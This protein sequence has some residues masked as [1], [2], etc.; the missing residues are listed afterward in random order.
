MKVLFFTIICI[1]F[2]TV[3]CFAH[4]PQLIDLKV[5]GLNIDIT[6]FHSVSQPQKHYINEIRVFVDGVEL[7]LQKFIQ[8]ATTEEQKAVYFIPSLKQGDVIR[9]FAKCSEE[10]KLLKEFKVE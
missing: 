6:V 7:V 3:S 9:V 10:G 2:L 5:D 8:Q 1:F 4:P